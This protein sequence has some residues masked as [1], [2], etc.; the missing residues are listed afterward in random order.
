MNF[1]VKILRFC[2]ILIYEDILDYMGRI[3]FYSV[4][5]YKFAFEVDIMANI[6]NIS[7]IF[8]CDCL[9]KNQI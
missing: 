5:I 4:I 9:K 7:F 1:K 6:G 8:F 2:H 3:I